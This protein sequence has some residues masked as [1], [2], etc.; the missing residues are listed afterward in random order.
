MP[1]D[2]SYL[3]QKVSYVSEMNSC[4]EQV[5]QRTETGVFENDEVLWSFGSPAC[6]V[7]KDDMFMVERPENFNL[8]GKRLNR[9]G[10]GKHR[11]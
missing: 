3:L 2:S 11:E 5:R 7:H 10:I 9:F 1:K 8:I 4:G 6:A